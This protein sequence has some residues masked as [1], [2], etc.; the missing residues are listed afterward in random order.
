MRNDLQRA[1]EQSRRALVPADPP[2]NEGQPV[3]VFGP[4]AARNEDAVF[5]VA[6]RKTLQQALPQIAAVSSKPAALSDQIHELIPAVLPCGDEVHE[7]FAPVATV[8]HQ[9]HQIIPAV[10]SVGEEIAKP[11]A[12]IAAVSHRVAAVS[13][14]VHEL[15]T[16]VTPFGEQISEHVA[17]ILA[18]AKR[19]PQKLTYVAGADIAAVVAPAQ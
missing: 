18:G 6:C 9:I 8:P 4:Q 15:I 2:A 17:P 14:Q 1:S 12:S 16:T 10:P 5:V 7:P 19:I 13:D 3:A 11:L